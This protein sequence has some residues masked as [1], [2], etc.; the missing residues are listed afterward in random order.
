MTRVR[1][2]HGLSTR[3]IRG[4]REHRRPES[5]NSAMASC[6]RPSSTSS[7]TTEAPALAK[8]LAA[9][10]PTPDA[11]PVTTATFALTLSIKLASAPAFAR[12]SS[13]IR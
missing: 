6:S 7:I 3:E 8:A 9:A 2:L 11:A 4:N 13:L 1:L 12:P 10:S 5:V